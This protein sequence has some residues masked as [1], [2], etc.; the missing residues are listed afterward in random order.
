[1]IE[2][3]KQTMLIPVK[4]VGRA[5]GNY[6]T[7]KSDEVVGFGTICLAIVFVLAVIW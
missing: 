3:I 6:A 2:S 7:M 5:V 4:K 1:M